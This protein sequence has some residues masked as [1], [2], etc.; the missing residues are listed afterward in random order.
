MTEIL[1]IKTGC[2]GFD[3]LIGG[4]LERKAIT[5]IYGEP[6]AGKST[7]AIMS[8]ASVLK[9]G[10]YVI[11]IDSEGFSIERFRQ[12]CGDDAEELSAN[13]FLF[14]PIDFTEQGLMIAE[15]DALLRNN[16]IGLII[17]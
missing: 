6:A 9:S 8:A 13:L 1:K 17:L 10:K 16:D 12:I 14:E 5:Q 4:G 2:T 11:V 15:C 7:I 3:E